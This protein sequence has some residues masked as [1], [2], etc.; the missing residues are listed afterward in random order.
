MLSIP[1][2][3]YSGLGMQ[4]LGGRT[5]PA[6]FG[7]PADW[8]MLAFAKPVALWTSTVFHIGAVQAL[9]SRVLNMSVLVSLSILTS[10]LFSVGLTLSA[11]GQ[12]P[13][14]EAAVKLAVFLLFGHWMEMTACRGSSDS[15]RKLLD[16]ARQT[17]T[18]ER[19]DSSAGYF[20]SLF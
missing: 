17:A 4:V 19:E 6:P 1:V 8:I 14:Y 12:E 16:L 9:K 18:V 3:A 11:P 5:L 7:I 20:T 2:V 15:V 10:H 13:S